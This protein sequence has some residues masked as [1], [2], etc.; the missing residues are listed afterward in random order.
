MSV[1]RTIYETLRDHYET[2]PPQVWW[3]EDPLEVVFGAV[4]VQ[5]STWKSV[6]RVLDS[7]KEQGLL[8]FHKIRELE[9]ERLAELIRSVGFQTKKAQRLRAMAELFLRQADGDPVRFFARDLETVRRELLT[10]KGIGPGATD[11][12][13]LY[14]GKFP[15]YMADPFTMRILLRHEILGP[16]AR[17][18]D[19]QKLV[20]LELTP[21]EEPYG[22]ELFGEF[23][24]LMV[25]VGRDF[26]DKSV[27][28]CEQC[29]LRVFLPE[30]GPSGVADSRKSTRTPSRSAPFP[31][32][33]KPKSPLKAIEELNLNETER[34]IV[35]QLDERPISIDAIIQ[36]TNLPVHVVRATIAILEMRKVVRQLEGNQVK[37]I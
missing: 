20:H 33:S 13:L 10:V 9:T 31:P 25:R 35:E 3:P 30:D 24:A 15:I 26:C 19:V 1:L 8:D 5:G 16:N 7:L 4:L 22:A 37:R 6:A 36:S 17:E 2:K 11:N 27:P 12:I 34:Q 14:A 21:D 18:D 29:P 28:A 23:Q 32:A